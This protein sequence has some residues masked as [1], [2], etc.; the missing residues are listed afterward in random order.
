MSLDDGTFSDCDKEHK[1]DCKN[2]CCINEGDAGWYRA[3]GDGPYC[4]DCDMAWRDRA[5]AT[6]HE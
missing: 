6:R 5:E 3:E 1:R 2:G 4:E